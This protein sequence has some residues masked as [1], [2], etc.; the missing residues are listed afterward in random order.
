MDDWDLTGLPGE[1]PWTFREELFAEISVECEY[2]AD[3]HHPNRDGAHGGDNCQSAFDTLNHA[4]IPIVRD[5]E[6]CGAWMT[7]GDEEDMVPLP[8]DS[9]SDYYTLS[10]V[11][12]YNSG[13]NLYVIN[14]GFFNAMLQTPAW[15]IGDGAYVDFNGNDYQ[16]YNVTSGTIAHA[17]GLQSG[18]IPQTLNSIDI[19]TMDGVMEAW[20]TLQQET[21]FELVV[22]RGTN[23]VTLD[24]YVAHVL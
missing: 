10:G 16:L 1:R 14:G 23:T 9:W 5:G 17:L 2:L 6:T 18:D 11:V 22:L 19:S 21:E 4:Q 24:Y 20:T 3:E 8:S 7:Y 15:L 12:A 13:F